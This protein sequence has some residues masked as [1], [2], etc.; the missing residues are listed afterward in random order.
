MAL[1]ENA[2]GVDRK[3][4]AAAIWAF[5]RYVV[6]HFWPGVMRQ[7]ATR[8]RLVLTRVDGWYE[9]RYAFDI[10]PLALTSK[11]PRRQP[12]EE[13]IPNNP[14]LAYRGMCW[15]EWEAVLETG[16]VQSRGEYN[17]GQTGLTL[18]GDAATAQHYASGFAP[19]PFKPVGDRLG[20]VV[21]YEKK[22]LLSHDSEPRVLAGEYASNKP[23]RI[24][25]VTE[26]W[27]LYPVR[28]KLGAV[29]VLVTGHDQIREGSRMSPTVWTVAALQ[30]WN[31]SQP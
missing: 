24:E 22:W 7:I 8:Y 11:P 6:R 20:V 2:A 19:W 25:D 10:I 18:F 17:I 21:A 3:T 15:E 16:F 4:F 30:L 29:E 28:V 13:E 14:S 1:F 9:I 23:L 5:R 12:V 31:R 26:V 27:F